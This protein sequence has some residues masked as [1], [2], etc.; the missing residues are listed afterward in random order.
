[1]NDST[2]DTGRWDQFWKSGRKS[3]CSDQDGSANADIIRGL[4][5]DFFASL[6]DG[7]RLIDLCTGNGAVVHVA[8]E[9]ARKNGNSIM[10]CGVDAASIAPTK[11]GEPQQGPDAYFVRASVNALPFE[12]RCFDAVTSQ[13]GIE[14]AAPER[15][16][17]ES[18]RVLNDGGRGLF[19][20]HA[21]GGVTVTQARAELKDIAELLDEIGI[22][23]AALEALKLVCAA[24]RSTRPVSSARLAE[25]RRAHDEFHERLARIGDSWQERAA[26][27]VFR[28]SGDILQHTFQ[29]RH[30][31]PVPV[32]IDKVRETEQSVILHRSRLQALRDAALG[33]EECE[34]LVLECRRHAAS[35]SEFSAVTAG[36]GA[37]Q[38]AWAIKLCK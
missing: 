16:I 19:V 23:P 11:A 13:F 21:S 26:L 36:D 25:A 29:N 20:A 34:Q 22:F 15:V 28:D 6:G 24:E 4:W 5:T 12:D 32:L 33:R 10:A 14:Y 37:S 30:A 38:L 9:C 35:E 1:M 31:F 7:Q 3:C 17:A 8:L 27:A 18:L 2:P